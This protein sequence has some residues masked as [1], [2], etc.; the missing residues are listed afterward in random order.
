MTDPEGNE[1]KLTPEE[2]MKL[3]YEERL[4]A[5]D[6]N[7]EQAV[8]AYVD[9]LGIAPKDV[10]AALDEMKRM[11]VEDEERRKAEAEQ[12]VQSKPLNVLLIQTPKGITGYGNPGL[13]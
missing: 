3:P 2:V 4:D 13:N 12:Q 11:I 1:K 8:S 7:L 10:L 9:A 5:M 6:T